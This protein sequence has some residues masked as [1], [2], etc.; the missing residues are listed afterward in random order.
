MLT[1]L[2]FFHICV[3]FITHFSYKILLKCSE[4]HIEDVLNWVDAPTNKHSDYY[5]KLKGLVL[6]VQLRQLLEDKYVRTGEQLQI[7]GWLKWQLNTNLQCIKYSNRTINLKNIVRVLPLYVTV[8][9]T[10]LI[11]CMQKIPM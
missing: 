9:L 8:N 2:V 1:K 7:C 10:I 4:F 3:Y 11:Q 5:L 6:P